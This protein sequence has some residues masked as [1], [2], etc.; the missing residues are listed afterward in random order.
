MKKLAA[1]LLLVVFLFHFI[2]YRGWFYLLEHQWQQEI[3]ISLDR[4]EYNEAELITI[5]APLMLPY[6][7]DTRAFQRTDGQVTVNGKVY[8]Y[9]KSKVEN[10]EYVLL[11]LP[12]HYQ[13]HLE[14]G[15]QDF[16]NY[17]NDITSNN[18]AKKTPENKPPFLKLVT[19]SD[20]N[21]FDLS[22]HN[23]LNGLLNLHPAAAGMLAFAPHVSP[24]QP[25]D[26]G[27]I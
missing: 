6:I 7:T 20:Q 15:K 19:E 3:Q 5:R 17:S 23:G 9:V 11:C 14:K 26:A 10:G 1:I 24:E 18:A 22:I 12:D 21:Y 16:F 25:P 27:N 4:N 13:Q 2:G 8:R